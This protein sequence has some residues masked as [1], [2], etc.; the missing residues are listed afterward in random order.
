MTN[1]IER[2]VVFPTL[3]KGGYLFRCSVSNSKNIMMIA[4]NLYIADHIEIKFFTDGEV[5]EKWVTD[6]AG[7]TI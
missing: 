4:S 7:G 3:K 2:L 1:D 6:R 5:A